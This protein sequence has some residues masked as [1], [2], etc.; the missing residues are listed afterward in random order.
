M[1]NSISSGWRG[2]FAVKEKKAY[3]KKGKVL[4]KE[5]EREVL[6]YILEMNGAKEEYYASLE[7]KKLPN[8]KREDRFNGAF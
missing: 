6:D 5:Q 3:G 2:L 1:D 4:S 8:L 7:N